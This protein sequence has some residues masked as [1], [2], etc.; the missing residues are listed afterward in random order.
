MAIAT[1]RNLNGWALTIARAFLAFTL[2]LSAS[3][4]LS[5]VTFHA[6]LVFSFELFLGAAIAAGWLMRYAAILVLLGT[7]AERVL[8]PH[9]NFALVPANTGTTAAVLIAS[10]I[11]VC[12]GQ[13]TG[14][15][16]AATI[17]DNDKSFSQ[18]SCGILCEFWDEDIDVAIRLEDGHLRS[19]WKRRCIVTIQ[20]RAGETLNVG[21]ECWYASDD[22]GRN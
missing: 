3:V 19:L 14:K 16:D 20:R 6:A 11:L 2:L 22:C 4:G 12:F 17:N 7:S 9:F 8:A 5:H 21:N 13:S 10:A 1:F 18:H 15:A